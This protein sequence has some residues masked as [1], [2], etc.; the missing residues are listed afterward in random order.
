MSLANLSID[1]TVNTGQAQRGLREV[2]TTAR[3]QFMR[4]GA[5]VDDFRADI[6]A[7]SSA[8]DRAARSMGAGMDRAA[9][10]I[11]ASA[12]RSAQAVAALSDA[13]NDTNF[14]GLRDRLRAAFDGAFDAAKDFGEK[15]M[16]VAEAGAKAAATA[17]AVRVAASAGATFVAAAARIFVAYKA[18]S[19]SLGFAKGLF[20]GESYKADSIDRLIARNTELMDGNSEAKQKAMAL[21]VLLEK[22][23]REN[24]EELDRL[25]VRYKDANGKL[26]DHQQFLRNVKS[27]LEEYAQGYD[28]VKAAEAIG[29][30]SLDDVNAALAD[31]TAALKKAKD[32]NDDYLLAIGPQGQAEIARYQAAIKEFNAEAQRSSDGFSH[33]IADS[34]MPA[35]T[36]LAEFFKDGWPVA[37]RW[38]R[39]SMATITSLFYGLK[40]AADIALETVRGS[41]QGLGELLVGAGSAA[42]KAFKGDFSGAADDMKRAWQLSGIAV[43]QALDQ[44][45]KDA[46]KNRDRMALAFGLDGLNAG[47]SDDKSPKGSKT[48]IP[49]PQQLPAAVKSPYQT[50]LDELDRMAVKVEQNE[51]ASLRLKAAQLAQKEGITDLTKAYEAVDR[52]QRGDSA[53][54]VEAHSQALYESANAYEFETSLIGK[55]A[56][57]QEKLIIAYQEWLDIDRQIRAAQKAGK[58]LDQMAIDDLKDMSKGWVKLRQNQADARDEFAR[59]FDVGVSNALNNYVRSATDAASN[60]A[61]LISGSFQRME[62][63]MLSFVHTGKLNLKDLFTYM[64]DEYIR[65]TIRMQLAKL[66]AGIANSLE[67]GFSNFVGDVAYV[68]GQGSFQLANGIDYVPYDGYPATLHEGEK[69]LTRQQ[70]QADRSGRSDAGSAGPS[71]VINVASGITH[72]E[73]AAMVPQLVQQIKNQVQWSSRRP[74]YVGVL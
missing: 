17:M 69:V 34:I 53:R 25:G 37:V 21:D 9:N 41:V 29:I 50:Y 19:A 47:P 64:A 55:N 42:V 3:E 40:T 33:A 14:D 52:V 28:R 39:G 6:L 16:H 4:S 45:A 8:L 12:E 49:K 44:V 2:G 13:A 23:M 71:V 57:E 38:F 74:G 68:F 62:D 18:L 11:E 70:A 1:V 67:G 7:A 31:H 60:V 43:S 58:P 10:E 54:V 59:S 48:F 35:L 56:L 73:F 61:T 5:A 24:G 32:R 51:Y 63:A 72:G 30:G 66:S 46:E 26:L 36:D 20:T 22:S 15:A 27:A 65:Q